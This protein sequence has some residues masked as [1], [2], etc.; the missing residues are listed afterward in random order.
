M[1]DQSVSRVDD[2]EMTHTAGVQSGVLRSRAQRE[3]LGFPALAVGQGN[4]TF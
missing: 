2:L 1:R 4:P 3:P